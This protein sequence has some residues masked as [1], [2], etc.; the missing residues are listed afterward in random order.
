MPKPPQYIVRYVVA[1]G[2][3][4]EW[5]LENGTPVVIL[6]VS[7]DGMVSINYSP[8]LTRIVTG[9]VIEAIK[10]LLLGRKDQP[11]RKLFEKCRKEV[12]KLQN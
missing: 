11:P 6:V 2:V 8:N 10:Q 12:S 4:M 7:K 9:V 1:P 5:S 3:S